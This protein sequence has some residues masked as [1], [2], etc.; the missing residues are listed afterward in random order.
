MKLKGAKGNKKYKINLT[1]LPI[2]YYICVTNSIFSVNA[3]GT[4]ER[5]K[6]SHTAGR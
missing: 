5:D 3:G 4:N 2:L 6:S 1:N